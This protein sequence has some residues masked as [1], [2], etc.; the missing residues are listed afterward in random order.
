MEMTEEFKSI[1]H[2]AFYG[3]EF[4]DTVHVDGF[5]S[6]RGKRAFTAAKELGWV[7]SLTSQSAQYTAINYTITQLGKE[8]L[9]G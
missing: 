7:E 6:L 4:I 9:R 8:H 1:L 3:P 5:T 2:T